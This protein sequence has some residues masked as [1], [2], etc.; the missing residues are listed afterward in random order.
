MDQKN[1][2]L[3]Q[4]LGLEGE[5]PQLRCATR[6]TGERHRVFRSRVILVTGMAVKRRRP[7]SWLV[8]CVCGE[9]THSK[10]QPV[11]RKVVPTPSQKLSCAPLLGTT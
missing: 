10:A 3:I 8:V 9:Q 5:A 6:L 1:K 2:D 7:C 11:G 4:E